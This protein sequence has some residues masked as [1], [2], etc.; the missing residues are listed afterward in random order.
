MDPRHKKRLKIIQE[1]YAL[2]FTKQNSLT[3]KTHLILKSADN[4]NNLI[5]KY[6]PKFPLKKI[7][8]IDLAIL[9]LAIFELVIEK[10]EPEKVIINEAVELA[11]EFGS[12]KSY[13]FVNAV[14]GRIYDEFSKT[15]K[16]D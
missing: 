4:L 3:H 5:E 13:G 10:Q 16:K 2:E 11:K 14:L 12:K 6:A 9:R 7:A 15:E 1:L 8:K